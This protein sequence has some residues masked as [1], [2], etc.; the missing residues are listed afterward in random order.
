MLTFNKLEITNFRS[1]RHA[2]LQIGQQGL[3][4]IRGE[5][6]DDPNTINNAAAK[7]SLI[8]SLVFCVFGKTISGQAADSV[9]NWDVCKDCSVEASWDDSDVSTTYTIKRYRKHAQH[10]NEVFFYATK[11]KTKTDLRGAGIKETQERIN[12]ILGIDYDTF[13]KSIWFGSE[14]LLRF[15]QSTDSERKET[16]EKILNIDVFNKAVKIVR[17]R[18]VEQDNK[19]KVGKQKLEQLGVS[20][21][22]E[23]TLQTSLKQQQKE[24]ERKKKQEIEIF[25]QKVVQADE[26]SEKVVKS[27][28]M[29]A[30]KIAETTV[31]QQQ[32]QDLRKKLSAVQ[33]KKTNIQQRYREEIAP[34]EREK[35]IKDAEIDR[36]RTELQ[37]YKS[38]VGINCPVC[39][40]PVSNDYIHTLSRSQLDTGKALKAEVFKLEET[41]KALIKQIDDDTLAATQ[42]ETDI[43]LQLENLQKDWTKAQVHLQT[44]VKLET[45]Q[46]N[47]EKQKTDLLKLI[48]EAKNRTSDFD[49]L[50]NDSIQ[51]TKNITQ[52]VEQTKEN[53]ADSEKLYKHLK[54]WEIG[55]GHRGIKS[56][57]MDSVIPFINERANYYS[58]I[59]TNG[60]MFIQISVQSKTKTGEIRERMDLKI[61]RRDKDTDYT[62]GSN[63]ERRKID[64]CL[65]LALQ[66]LVASRSLKSMNLSVF[67]EVF[68]TLDDAG[69][70]AVMQLL[71]VLRQ[72]RNT[73]FVISHN[74]ELKNRFSKDIL[75]VKEN[76]ISTVYQKTRNTDNANQQQTIS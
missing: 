10:L 13:V 26:L 34:K 17:D 5:N 63:S 50:L 43:Q 1:L 57:L 37:K 64:L 71:N 68:D 45:E 55:F 52:A 41:I 6:K 20:A 9:V 66:D 58:Q 72:S 25:S 16:L 53:M 4:L 33:N 48:E 54:F 32:M 21:E 61:T 56:F 30:G 67:D 70:D 29:N 31:L 62:D 27:L 65:S 44:K 11:G 8:E 74:D 38:M 22:R 2:I 46:S 69:V 18:M 12:K 15:S 7:T 35:A 49:D 23:E 39:K 24:F 19:L 36:I 14:S 47:Y 75:V 59:L 28:A 51:K 3:V 40:Q 42:A 76:G 60:Q 73:I